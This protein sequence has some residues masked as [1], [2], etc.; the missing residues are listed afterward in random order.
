[1]TEER[2]SPMTE[3]VAPKRKGGRP[4][5]GSVEWSEELACW[6]VR[7]T[8]AGKRM[9]PIEMPGIPREDEERAKYMGRVT[10]KRCRALGAV[11]ETSRETVNEYATRWLEAR[12]GR[13][14]SVRDNRGHLNV[15]VLPI[16]GTVAMGQVTRENIEAV[17]SSL[18]A[19]VR[20]GQISAKTAQN[21]WGT[22][23]KL[24][25]DATNA[26]PAEGL[27]CLSSDPTDNVR[28]PDD[29]DADKLLQFLY[30]SEFTAFVSCPHVPLTWRR[31]VAIAVYLCLRD[32]EQRALKWTAVDLEHGVISVVERFDRRT[33]EDREGTKSGAAR[34]I[35]IHAN[36]I[37]LLEAMHEESDGEGYVCEM[38]SLRDMARGLR[39][40][41][42]NAGIER[43]A[44]HFGTTVSKAC[45]W[46][47]LRASGLTWLAVEGRSP[48][49]IRDIAGHSQ[50][51][52][53]DR[54]VR[55]AAV[56]RGGR[57]GSPF[58]ALPGS[59]LEAPEVLVEFR[60][61]QPKLEANYSESLRGGRGSKTMLLGKKSSLPPSREAVKTSAVAIHSVPSD[62]AVLA[63]VG[64]PNPISPDEIRSQI[65]KATLAGDWP[66]VARLASLLS[67]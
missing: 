66:T 28:G 9:A 24:F 17:V 65:L 32:G 27:R 6:T 39:R 15:H 33:G 5:T 25:D 67:T 20:D 2:T 53:T 4:A 40:W 56:L 11:P 19:K 46:H 35:P 49:E 1:M 64:P 57:F 52:M 44:L 31:N 12:E 30:P 18:D 63:F 10:S 23:S 42:R 47:D 36:L 58:P 38:P 62:T 41:L 14:A 13:V 8:V 61:S 34:Q 60:L 26:K 29:D 7:V 50:T 22:M 48:S 45:R 51:Q 3:N 43:E 37:P 55:S 59:L 16:I 21:A 54:Y